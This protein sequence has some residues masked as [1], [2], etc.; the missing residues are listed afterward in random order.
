MITPTLPTRRVRRLTA[1][2]AL[3][4]FPAALLVEAL[5][6]PSS[7]GTGETYL[8]AATD[9]PGALT[10]AAV[11]LV[12]SAALT[13]PAVAGILHQARDRGA[14]LANAGAVFAVLGALA[15]M[16]IATV[17]LVA[18]GLPGGDPAQ[19]IAFVDRMNDRPEVGAVVLP[20]VLSFG[21]GVALLAWAAWRAGLVGW[22]GPALVTAVV[23]AHTALP[24][25]SPAVEFAGLTAIA[26]VF[27]WLGVQVLRLP[28]RAW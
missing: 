12:V 19:M 4:G 25:V 24:E 20:L 7:G 9:Q 22:W 26:V 21:L 11:A 6:D 8:A 17:A 13:P 18:L 15:H 28:D 3:L 16:G 2:I 27:G 10:A 5:V 14:A 23:V 1:G